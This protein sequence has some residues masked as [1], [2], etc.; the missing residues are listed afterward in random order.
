MHY[1]ALLAFL[2]FYHVLSQSAYPEALN[3]YARAFQHLSHPAP[4][5]GSTGVHEFGFRRFNT[6]TLGLND[7]QIPTLSVVDD[8]FDRHRDLMEQV[9]RRVRT[10]AGI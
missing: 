8:T 4:G 9:I 5:R 7:Y 10:R 2:P 1:D 6:E 3:K